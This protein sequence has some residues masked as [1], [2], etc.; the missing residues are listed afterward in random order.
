M[1]NTRPGT[2]ETCHEETTV[3]LTCVLGQFANYVICESNGDCPSGLESAIAALKNKLKIK[4]VEG[5]EDLPLLTCTQ[6]ELEGLLKST[7]KEITEIAQWQH[8][9]LDSLAWSIAQLAIELTNS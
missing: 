9:G 5:W 1:D 3:S 6:S 8:I 4:F 2:R 7:F